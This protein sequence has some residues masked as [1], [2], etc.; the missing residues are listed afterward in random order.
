[1]RNPSEITNLT[2]SLTARLICTQNNFPWPH[3]F[4]SV[5]RI[6]QWFV[7]AGTFSNFDF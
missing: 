7:Q 2:T 6:Y 3:S 4:F 5:F 1:M